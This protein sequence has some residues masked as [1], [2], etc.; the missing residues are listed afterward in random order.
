[1]NR[2]PR[3]LVVAL[4]A[5]S[6]SAC[7]SM[8]D[9]SNTMV[10]ATTTK[11]ALDVSQDPT[12]SL[13]VTL[14]YKRLEAVW[15]PLLPNQ[16]KLNE[17]A[18]ATCTGGTDPKSCPMFTGAD[19]TNTDTYSVLATFSGSASG[20]AGGGSGA[21]AKGSIAQFFA[22]GLAAR[23]LASRG[24]NA[25]LFNTEA[26]VVADS[27]TKAQAQAQAEAQA[28]ELRD[29]AAEVALLMNKLTQND[30]KSIDSGK[31]EKW[32]AQFT[33]KSVLDGIKPQLDNLASSANS[34]DLKSYLR[35]HW[36]EFG[37]EAKAAAVA[38]GL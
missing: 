23:A 22:T 11:T 14:G 7:T 16:G 37:A 21:N 18:P 34:S 6:L 25:A 26:N 3:P 24:G 9:H 28:K 27:V 1:M 29:N 31:Y 5:L 12:G 15:M 30:G 4:A 36:N 2:S 33:A 20:I 35:N 8:M 38:A 13:G 19:G 17:R 10:F 32:K